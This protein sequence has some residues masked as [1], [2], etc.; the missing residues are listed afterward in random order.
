[1]THDL[2]LS[3]HDFT[4]TL[5]FHFLVKNLRE[6]ASAHKKFAKFYESFITQSWSSVLCPQVVKI[7]E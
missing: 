2:I 3:C 4:Q 1:M 5:K 6:I 7:Y